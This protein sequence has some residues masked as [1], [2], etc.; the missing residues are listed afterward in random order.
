VLTVTSYRTFEH[1]LELLVEAIMNALR[2][3][4]QL[5]IRHVTYLELRLRSHFMEEKR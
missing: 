5:N 4:S 2:H 1:I 3:S